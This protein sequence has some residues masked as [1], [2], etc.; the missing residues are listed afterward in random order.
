MW[1]SGAYISR[2]S[3]PSNPVQI[4]ADKNE[5]KKTRHHHLLCSTRKG[6][7]Y[8]KTEDSPEKKETQPR[9][10]SYQRHVRPAEDFTQKLKLKL[11]PKPKPQAEPPEKPTKV[12]LTFNLFFGG[13]S[14]L[15]VCR[16]NW[17]IWL[18]KKNQKPATAA[19]N[20]NQLQLKQQAQWLT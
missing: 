11:K 13:V 15:K 19:A 3:F 7:S 9:N 2:G 5:I 17:F 14:K 10:H 18:K 1:C 6:K 4:S 12:P 8:R 20:C 16:W